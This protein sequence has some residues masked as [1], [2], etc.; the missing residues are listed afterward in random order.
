[1]YFIAVYGKTAVLGLLAALLLWEILKAASQNQLRVQD[2]AAYRYYIFRGK[3]TLNLILALLLVFSI[4]LIPAMETQVSS[5]L[6]TLN[7]SGASQG[8]APNGTR[9]NQAAILNDAV[10]E[11]AIEKGAWENVRPQDL[12]RTLRVVPAVEGNSRLEE[13]YHIS[14]QFTLEYTSIPETA[15]IR[16]DLITQLVLEAY[17]EIFVSQYS[18]NVSSLDF[19]LDKLHEN[20]YLDICKYFSDFLNEIGNY[21][22]V[23]RDKNVSFRSETTGD[24][25]WHVASDAYSARD[26]MLENLESY[27]L[28]TGLSK[29]EGTYLGSLS[30]ENVNL[31]FD[32]QKYQRDNENQLEAITMYENDMAQ[33]V[34]VPT[35]DENAQ[36]YM[37]RTRIG[38]D[39]FASAAEN[40]AMEMTSTRNE[41]A[42]NRYISQMLLSNT[43]SEKDVEKSESMIED[44]EMQLLELSERAKTLIR[45][46]GAAQ[47][48]RYM[49]IIPDTGG[50]MR[51]F[52]SNLLFVFVAAVMLHLRSYLREV[53]KAIGGNY[54]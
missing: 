42:N 43:P 51:V 26:V 27:I 28:E 39:D 7:Y 24:T 8:L 1:M 25:F 2:I 10:L 30:F 49:T 11:R 48:N 33:T 46:Y 3:K 20:D 36:F 38:V 32:A 41:I 15:H 6:L 9:F 22:M 16:G 17:K 14:T 47:T 19:E 5:A 18:D 31:D 53:R 12:K 35:Y 23:M 37:S 50:T 45:E 40:A 21:M 52:L 13:E 54:R 34:L 29:E 4:L 44:I